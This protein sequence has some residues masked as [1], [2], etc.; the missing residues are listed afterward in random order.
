MSNVKA[1]PQPGELWTISV[2]SVEGTYKQTVL[3]LTEK[4]DL[5]A[6]RYGSEVTL[7]ECLVNGEKQSLPIW[8][9]N[10]AD[11]ISLNPA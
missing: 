6:E 2:W 4:K 8:M 3:V 10:T 1:N 7:Y 9:F 11:I 5:N